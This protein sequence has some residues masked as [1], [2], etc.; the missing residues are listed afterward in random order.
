M[1]A[2][3]NTDPNVTKVLID[4]GASVRA[5]ADDGKNALMIAAQRP[6]TRKRSSF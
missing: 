3:Q 1:F 5:K 6:A 2:A 4:A